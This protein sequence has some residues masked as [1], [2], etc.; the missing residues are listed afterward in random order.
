MS[1]Q[2]LR[3]IASEIQSEPYL[4]VDDTTGLSNHEHVVFIILSVNDKLI[5]S[6]DFISC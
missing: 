4:M 2:I 1:L 6:E 3:E 5:I